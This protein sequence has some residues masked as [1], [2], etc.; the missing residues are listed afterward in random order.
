MAV[1]KSLTWQGTDVYV[2][3]GTVSG[4]FAF[5]AVDGST[6]AKITRSTGSFVTDGLVAGD[7]IKTDVA[8]AGPFIIDTVVA[9]ELTL[10][11]PYA[12]V[13]DATAATVVLTKFIPLGE[14]KGTSGL[15]GGTA[16]VIPATHN[17]SSAIEKKKGLPDSGQMTVPANLLLADRG[18][19]RIAE[20]WALP[21][22][23]DFILVY[24]ADAANSGY[25][26][27]AEFAALVMSQAQEGEVD[28][29]W[30]I[31]TAL[32]ITGA[33]TYVRPPAA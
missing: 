30:S 24:A 11:E 23:E 4:S 15:G 8:N 7:L 19:Q 2:K 18:Q 6:P 32:E 3:D 10:V 31:S 29:L 1:S 14:I 27:R 13:T 12:A 26:S 22:P 21:D 20:L 5:E 16:A 17:R 28:G 33:I 25:R 9:L